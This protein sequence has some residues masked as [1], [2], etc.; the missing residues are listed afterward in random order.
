MLS[1]GSADRR[2]L[3]GAVDKAA[4]DNRPP[5]ST[6]EPE[7]AI[8]TEIAEVLASIVED[9]I[10]SDSQRHTFLSVER[11]HA[12]QVSGASGGPKD[13]AKGRT[14]DGLSE[15]DSDL[16]AKLGSDLGA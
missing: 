5:I 9:P 11:V 15:R 12:C 1:P 13:F 8:A 4:V 6:I 7:D 3:G 14:V 10:P 2:R 16:G